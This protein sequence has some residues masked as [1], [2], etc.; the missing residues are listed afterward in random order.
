MRRPARGVFLSTIRMG[1]IGRRGH[2][3]KGKHMVEYREILRLHAMGGQ[4]AEHL[5]LMQV[6]EGDGEERRRQ[7]KGN[8]PGM[9]LARGEDYALTGA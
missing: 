8:E 2:G 6:L 4:H 1:R 9:A 7:G 3:R 5:V